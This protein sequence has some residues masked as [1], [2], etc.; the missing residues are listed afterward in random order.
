[1]QFV[2]TTQGNGFFR[3]RFDGAHYP[4]AGSIPVYQSSLPVHTVS[5]VLSE[6]LIPGSVVPADSMET[7][8][9]RRMS[10]HDTS[11]LTKVNLVVARSQPLVQMSLVPI[12]WN[13]RTK[14]YEKLVSFH[15][16]VQVRDMPNA[17]KSQNATATENS[18]LASGSW[19]KIRISKSGIYKITYE[20][21]K[22]MGFPLDGNS[23]DIALYGNGGGVLP[24]QNNIPVPE[25]LTENP[26]EVVDG[27]DG[28]MNPGD[29]ILFYG[30]GP[31]SWN[32]N[33]Q[34]GHF[35]H[36]DNYYSDYA[37]YFLT[38]KSAPGKRIQTQTEPTGTPDVQVNSFT[39][40]AYHELDERNLGSTGRTW[41]GE[42]FDFTTSYDFNFDFPHRLDTTSVFAK[43]SLASTA[44]STNS[45]Q[46]YGNGVLE[47]QVSMPITGTS[48]YDVGKGGGTEF[49]Y[50]PSGSTVSLNI[51]YL[52]S[53]AASVGYLDCID[54]NAQR[55]LIFNGNQMTFT[56]VFNRGTLARYNLISS[57]PVQVWDITNPLNAASVPL[58]EQSATYQFTEPVSS[59]QQFIAFNGTE[60]Y[61]PEFVE[62]VQ[63]QNLHAVKNID[64]LIVSYPEFLP[65]AER[66]AAYHEQKDDMKVYVTTPQMIYNEFS[67]GAQDISAIRNFIKRLYDISDAGQKI[68]YLLLFG[69][70]SYDYKN[71]LKDNTDF[72]PCWE[73]VNSLNLI[74]SIATDDYYGY[75]DDG[76]GNNSTDR[77]D[78]GIGRFPVDNLDEA[79]MAVDKVIRYETQSADNMGPWRNLITFVAD[80]GDNNTHL[81]DAEKLA[82]LVQNQNPALNI[83]KLYLDAFPQESTPSGQRAP[84]LNEAIDTRIDN[85][86]LI[87]NYSGHGGVNG[88]GHERF[89]QLSD[90]NSWDNYNKLAVFITATCEF[91]AFDNPELISAGE[92]TFLNP[93]GG[94]I[95][96]F[97]TTRA[98]YASSNLALNT[99]IYNHN[100]LEKTGGLYPRF[101]DVIRKSKVLGGD[102]DKKFTLIGDP[103]LRLNYPQ[104]SAQTKAINEQPVDSAQPDTLKALAKV[105]I[106]GEILNGA[107][108]FDPTYNGLIYPTVYDKESKIYT[109]GTD[110]DSRVTAFY[111]W[112]NIL[113]NGK[114]PVTNGRFDFSFVVPKD[115]AYQYGPGRM[116]YYFTNGS[117]DGNG[118]SP[119]IIVGG[120]DQQAVEDTTGPHIKLYM[121]DSTFMSGGVTDENPSLYAVV[122]DSNGIN[123]SGIGIGHDMVATLDDDPAKTYNLNAFYTAAEGSFT[124]GTVSYPFQNLSPGKHSV[125]LK[126]WDLYNNSATATIDFVVQPSGKVVVENLRNWPNPARGSTDFVFDHNLAGQEMKVEIDI[127]QLDGRRVK[128]IQTTLQPE[129]FTSG[130]IHWDG[131]SDNGS[132]VSAGVYVYQ[133]IITTSDGASRRLQSKMV[134]IP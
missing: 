130:R 77:V 114:A 29:Y 92:W 5:A 129:G 34:T 30:K 8:L 49:T 70:A 66:L 19:F 26:I 53:D 91:S 97:T 132:R 118:Y 22:N 33:S 86:T 105:H 45:F 81:N 54:V 61:T 3:V 125:R 72:V 128:T 119:N 43:V 18:V 40:Y 9:L 36:Q 37:Y 56:Y 103:A 102:N 67:S 10:F 84:A 79:K 87:F 64:Y 52:R 76:E 90:I 106:Q 4:G 35:L 80:D 109:L 17:Y 6:K 59:V 120:F 71:R 127:Y 47:S 88:L 94:A 75:L 131:T 27:G 110:A 20:E 107:G 39:D 2:T 108:Q 113:F 62:Q 48:G 126:V 112:K 38:L 117:I 133:A 83:D 25:D 73:S 14:Q 65:Q 24:E 95:A 46:I 111:L 85:G 123:T 124:R 60:Y 122:S 51:R 115:I 7:V 104:W 21:L 69:D 68:K 55:A 96:L 63:N 100:M 23:A 28:T 31:V 41:Y 15:L 32:Y 82:N 16:I 121:N 58:T 89:M 11:F 1:M 42:V 101:G 134:F 50:N 116:A 98:T 12:R 44:Q 78:I 74:S 13:P 57:Q 93:N 99:A